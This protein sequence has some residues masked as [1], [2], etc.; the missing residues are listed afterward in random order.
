MK[1]AFTIAVVCCIILVTVSICNCA[2]YEKFVPKLSIIVDEKPEKLP[3]YVLPNVKTILTNNLSKISKNLYY[4]N[5]QDDTT[6]IIGDAFTLH[7]NLTKNMRFLTSIPENN[8]ALVLITPIEQTKQINDGDFRV[9]Y[10]NDDQGRLV[11]TIFE[12]FKTPITFTLVSIGDGTVKSD[13]FTKSNLNAIARFGTK[14]NVN[15]VDETLK[16]D[17][18]DYGELIDIHKLGVSIPFARREVIDF[19]LI[20]PQLKGKRAKL[21][22]VVA[23]DAIIMGDENIQYSNVNAD[24]WKILEALGRPEYINFYSMYFDV[25]DVSRKYSQQNDIFALKRSSLQIL[26][27][28]DN[29]GGVSITKKGNLDGF[30]DHENGTL[31]IKGNSVDGVALAIGVRLTLNNQHREEENGVY[32]VIATNKYSESV[33]TKGRQASKN[34]SKNDAKPYAYVCYGDQSIKSKEQC[35]SLFDGMGIPKTK[36]SYWDRPCLQNNE[37][38]FY[39]ANKNYKNYRGGCIDGRCEMPIGVQAVSYRMYDEMTQPS[40]HGCMD[41]TNTKCCEEQKNKQ[42]YPGLVSPDYAFEL[43]QFERIKV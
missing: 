14:N 18:V 23:F 5:K 35:E 9:G 33:L 2:L 11:K 24:L 16:I 32:V 36:R 15:D 22:S 29:K 25:F 17:V 3:L 1:K 43:D 30:Y 20:Y 41:S 6:L 8:A 19:A 31:I 38:P 42:T 40:C 10:V 12:S 34:E 13:T 21:K 37:C 7:T 26:E 39:Q 27:Q 28:Y 4:T